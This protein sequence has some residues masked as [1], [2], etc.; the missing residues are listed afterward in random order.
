MQSQ[1]KLAPIVGKDGIS[2]KKG[3]RQELVEL[4]A[5][6]GRMLGIADGAKVGQPFYDMKSSD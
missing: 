1:S 4:D 3:A 5:T 6:L 2:G